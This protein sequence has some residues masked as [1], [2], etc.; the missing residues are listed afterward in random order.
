MLSLIFLAYKALCLCEL[1]SSKQSELLNYYNS[2][3]LIS[4]FYTSC[5]YQALLK[6]LK[7]LRPVSTQ[8]NSPRI[9]P[10]RNK[11]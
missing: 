7:G 5:R 8:E 11:I 10:D 3:R 4:F 2:L 6:N 1:L 9:G